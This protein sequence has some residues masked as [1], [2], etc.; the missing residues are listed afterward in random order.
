MAVLVSSPVDT[1]SVAVWRVWS[2]RRV[3]Q[4]VVNHGWM[5]CHEGAAVGP[6]AACCCVP[7]RAWGPCKWPGQS[8]LCLLSD[9]MQDSKHKALLLRHRATTLLARPSHFSHSTPPR[10]RRRRRSCC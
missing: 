8:P 3:F 9:F 4:G 5:A 10:R 7:G 6:T 2:L 1:G